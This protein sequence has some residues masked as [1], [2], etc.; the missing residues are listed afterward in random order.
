M[1]STTSS[2]QT[3]VEPPSLPISN[4]KGGSDKAGT[5]TDQFPEGGTAAWCTVIGGV[6]I[7]FCTFGYTVSFGVYQDYY[8]LN[9]LT[10]ESPST[11]SWIGSINAFLGNGFGIVAG[12]LHDRGYFYHLLIGG[13]LLQSVSMFGLSL[14]RP[15]QFYAILL[16]QGI[17]LGLAQGLLFVP[18]MAVVSQYF[19]QRRTLAMSLVISGT[20]IGSLIHPIMLNYLFN[21][22]VGFA[23][24]V[25]ISATMVTVLLLIACL[26]MRTRLEATK[27]SPDYISVGRRIAHDVPFCLMCV[28]LLCFEI[29]FLFPL[30]Y[31]QLDSIKHGNSE[32]F[33]FYTFVILNGGSL[34]G[35]LSTGSVASWIGVPML[36]SITMASCG[37]VALSMI[38]LNGVVTVVVLGTLYGYFSG[39]YIALMAPL[40]AHLSGDLSELGARMGIGMMFAGIG[41]LI[42][43]P[44]SGALLTTQY[45]WWQPSVFSGLMALTGSLVLVIMQLA[46]KR[47]WKHSQKN[48]EAQLAGLEA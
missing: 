5:E 8:T 23:N 10:N 33:S 42:G 1:P 4:E 6:L 32:T 30:F 26:L 40:M 3:V 29:G 17:G 39:I 13:S 45:R 7:L 25:R 46:L 14:A 19:C 2:I 18:T 21:S 20:S 38:G 24:G 41:C 43:A 35:R 37:V 27:K 9:Y 15:G 16:A 47:H 48:L 12:V 31:M 36:M 11:I 34:V 28:G 22:R 44:I